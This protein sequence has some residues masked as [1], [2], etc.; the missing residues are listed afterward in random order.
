VNGLLDDSAPVERQ[1]MI[2]EKYTLVGKGGKSFAVRCALWQ[3]PGASESFNVTREEYEAIIPHQSHLVLTTR[4]GRL[5]MEWMESKR[6]IIQPGK[7]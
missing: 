7:P 4:A 5:G 3:E 6:V 1:A 2:L